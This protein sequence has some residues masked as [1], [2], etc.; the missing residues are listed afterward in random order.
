MHIGGDT[1]PGFKCAYEY[2]WNAC[3]PA[4][5]DYSPRGRYS[6]TFCELYPHD[7]G[8]TLFDYP[9]CVSRCENTFICHYLKVDGIPD[10]TETLYIVTPD[11]LFEI[12]QIA[13]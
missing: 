9:H 13:C 1:Y 3:G 6:P 5:F 4:H 7:I 2:A 10:F 12:L 8:R 11:R